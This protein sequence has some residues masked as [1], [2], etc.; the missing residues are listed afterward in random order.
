[1]KA[2]TDKI[3]EI[4]KDR[5]SPQYLSEPIIKAS[6]KDIN[7]IAAELEPLINQEVERRIADRMPSEEQIDEKALFSCGCQK[8]WYE[9]FL[10]GVEWLQIHST[11]NNQ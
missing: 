11:N 6:D 2:L 4:L 9:G 10:H 3:I 7:E 1:M 8:M 5:I